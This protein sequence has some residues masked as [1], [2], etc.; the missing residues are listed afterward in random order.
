MAIFQ[1]NPLAL[2]VCIGLLIVIGCWLI[3]T[4]DGDDG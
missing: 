1:M 2:G 4:F 3:E